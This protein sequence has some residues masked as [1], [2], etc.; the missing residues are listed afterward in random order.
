MPY[1]GHNPTNAGSFIEI[2]DF[3]STFNGANDSGTDVV[4]FT[5]QVGGVD[6]TPN[7]ANV[8]VMLDGVLQQPPASYSI[9][10]STLT[11]TEAPA[12][13]T[14]LY[15]VL[16]GQSASVGQGTITAA[17]LAISGNGTNNQLLKTDGDGTFSYINQNTVT[18]ST[19][20][21]LATARAING[22]N[23]DG[24][25]AITVT[26]AAGTLSGNTLK[27]TVTASS[28]TS[29]GTLSSLTLGGDLTLPQKIV[30]SGDTDT[31]LSFGDDSLSLYTGNNSASVVDFIYGN[32]YIKGNNKALVG[33][34]SS[35]SAKE[36]IKIDGSNVVQIAEGSAS[37][38]GGGS[39]FAGNITLSGSSTTR[40]L[41]LN[42]GGNGGVWQEGNYELRFGTNDTERMKIEGDGTVVMNGALQPAGNVSGGGYLKGNQIGVGKTP[43]SGWEFDGE[44]SSGNFNMRLKATAANQGAR[45]V[46]DSH[47]GDMGRITFESGGS[48]KSEIRGTIGDESLKFY[49][50]NANLALTL[51]NS[52]EGIFSG[53]LHVGSNQSNKEMLTVKGYNNRVMRLK[54]L[55][56]DRQWQWGLNTGS[57]MYYSVKN[58]SGS[59][60]TYFGVGVCPAQYHLDVA[61]D[62]G[63]TG[64]ITDYSLREL[65]KDIVEID[66]T[67]MIDKLKKLPLYKYNM[68]TSSM[69]RTSDDPV[70]AKNKGRYGLIADD[71]VNRTEFPELINWSK[72]EDEEK[73][74]VTGVDTTSYIGILHGAIKELIS[75]VEALE[76]A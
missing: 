23:F 70:Y 16:I 8:L 14:D 33:Y 52:Q 74:K 50:N 61:G 24:S 60:S 36:L 1:I 27:N 4:A 75:K 43:D 21:T 19:A 65:K 66:G 56:S 2:D 54:T 68:K 3:S 53:A 25:A 62:I 38:F 34:N 10:G 11:F 5:L 30:H 31:F 40:Y 12:S 39:T 17:E 55:G 49:T 32:I 44:T 58:Y 22:V 73:P 46:M 41:F 15:A 67:G 51:D 7:T 64:S 57:A 42:S 29:V 20:A 71:E 59:G 76:N 6:I 35:S 45:L 28:L 48:Q 9:S 63:Y 37:N 26:A 13:G 47:S 18:A 72:R 69:Q